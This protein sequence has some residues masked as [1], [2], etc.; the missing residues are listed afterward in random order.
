MD[1]PPKMVDPKLS[2]E[3]ARRDL[4]RAE[5]EVDAALSA[6]HK[7][8]RAEKTGITRAMED[9]FE[10]VRAARRAL[11]GVALDELPKLPLK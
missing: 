2:L 6:L 3:I 1:Q 10:K 8:V 7:T 4:A 9:A 11:D 5:A